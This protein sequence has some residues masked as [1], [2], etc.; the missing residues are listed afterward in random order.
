MEFPPDSLKKK[1][2]CVKQWLRVNQ[3][4]WIIKMKNRN[5]FV[6]FV[7]KFIRMIWRLKNDCCWESPTVQHWPKRSKGKRTSKRKERKKKPN[8][9]KCISPQIASS[10]LLYYLIFFLR[11][12]SE[13]AF[14]K[15]RKESDGIAT[16]IGWNNLWNYFPKLCQSMRRT[17]TDTISLAVET[18]YSI[19]WA[20]DN[21]TE[22]KL[23]MWNTKKQIYVQTNQNHIEN[24]LVAVVSANSPKINWKKRKEEKKS[25]TILLITW[26]CLKSSYSWLTPK[27]IW[28]CN[29]S[30]N[31]VIIFLGSLLHFMIPQLWLSSVTSEFIWSASHLSLFQQLATLLLLCVVLAQILCYRQ[32]IKFASLFVFLSPFF[33]SPLNHNEMKNTE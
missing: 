6:R 21:W 22:K 8:F 4:C 19:W 16:K 15:I 33:W 23:E 14:I 25:R 20:M 12:K 9:S 31:S 28:K 30:L 18:T 29:A 13:K 3:K 7:N 1:R 32:T 11:S 17:E 5:R 24:K 26:D 10:H 2:W 27:T